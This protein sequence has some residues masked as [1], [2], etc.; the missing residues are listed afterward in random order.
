MP[1]PIKPVISQPDLVVGTPRIIAEKGIYVLSS[2]ERGA[3]ELRVVVD[4]IREPPVSYRSFRPNEPENYFGAY[5]LVSLGCVVAR[6]DLK[7]LHQEIFRYRNDAAKN[8]FDIR[9][10]YFCTQV[11][12]FSGL[13]QLLSV[14]SPSYSLEQVRPDFGK[15]LPCPITEIWFHAQN[16]AKIS[17]RIEYLPLP[18]LEGDPVSSPE[19]KADDS[20]SKPANEGGNS[21]PPSGLLPTTPPSA[22]YHP[23]DQDD[24][25]TTPTGTPVSPVGQ[26]FA[27]IAGIDGNN[28]TY[29]G[30]RQ[31]LPGATNGLITPTLVGVHPSSPPGYFAARVLYDGRYVDEPDGYSSYTFE[32]HPGS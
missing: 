16:E 1:N 3:W 13:A 6:Y 12:E 7:Y 32:Y 28:R 5:Q 30:Y 27:V 2:V 8:Q 10:L 17:V 18:K 15:H 22:P 26:W 11:F 23:S 4:V 14:S 24:G 21:S 19:S 20:P 29:S 25:R 31:A 9:Y